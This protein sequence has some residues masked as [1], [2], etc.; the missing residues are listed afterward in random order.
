LLNDDE[1]WNL[2]HTAFE[3]HRRRPA[4]FDSHTAFERVAQKCLGLTER[5]HFNAENSNIQLEFLSRGDLDDV[6][7]Y[8]DRSEPKGDPELHHGPLVMIDIHG[9]RYAIDGNNRVNLWRDSGAN[10]PHIAIIV[11]PRDE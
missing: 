4:D 7:V 10:G 11:K 5:R 9:K 8:H 2:V 1:L 6:T 3:A